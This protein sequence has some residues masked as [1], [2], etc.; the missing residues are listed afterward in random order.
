MGIKILGSGSFVPTTKINNIELFKKITNFDEKRAKISLLKK[1]KIKQIEGYSPAEI[2]D[3][4]VQQVCGIEQRV[5]LH[6]QK[7]NL[8]LTR[9]VEDMAAEAA[10]K[11]L[12]DAK[13]TAA[14][15]D[16]IIFSTYSAEMLIPPPVCKLK[17]LL[18]ITDTSL[19]GITINS[20]C[21]GFVEAMRQAALYLQTK[22]Y[23]KILVVAAEYMSNK[24][25]FTDPTSCILFAD[26]A[27]ACVVSETKGVAY[28]EVSHMNY[29]PQINMKNNQNIRLSGGP[30]VER[31]AVNSMFEVLH[32]ALGDAQ[33]TLS[34]IDFIIP[35]QA[36]NRIIE[37]L[38]EKI[39]KINPAAMIVNN[40][41]YLGNLSSASI[42]VALDDLRHGRIAEYQYQSGQTACLTAVGGGYTY[43]SLVVE[44]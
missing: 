33:L 28:G 41:K 17:E 16:Y 2:F 15:I 25:D 5:F 37:A 8:S 31:H 19:S 11:A 3:L 18:G 10:K 35:H 36:N 7:D 34:D 44:L 27:G 21:N 4:W 6:H 23:R 13:I 39:L 22:R 30:L 38:K 20:V 42:V 40:I 12:V 9:E 24:I 14:D 26:G 43:S 29:S 1:A 32:A